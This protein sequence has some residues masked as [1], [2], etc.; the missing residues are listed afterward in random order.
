MKKTILWLLSVLAAFA[1]EVGEGKPLLV[2]AEHEVAPSQIVKVRYALSL[3]GATNA[4]PRAAL[5]SFYFSDSAGHILAP[6]GLPFSSRSGAWTYIHGQANGVS[7]EK[8]VRAPSGAVKVKVKIS[9]FA[10]GSKMRCE[11]L[12]I[13]VRDSSFLDYFRYLPIWKLCP[14][15]AVFMFFLVAALHFRFLGRNQA[16]ESVSLLRRALASLTA[17]MVAAFAFWSLGVSFAHGAKFVLD[18]SFVN[19]SLMFLFLAFL[20]IG[21]FRMLENRG[22]FLGRHPVA[23]M[24]I[25]FLCVHAMV[26]Q[27]VDGYLQMRMS[28]DFLQVQRCLQSPN[29]VVLH[30]PIFSYWCNHELLLSI[31]GKIFGPHLQVAQYLNALCCVG[32]LFPVFKLVE[33]VSGRRIATF[34]AFLVG[35]YPTNYLYST[36]LTSEYLCAFFLIWAFFFLV[37]ADQCDGDWKSSVYWLALCGANLGLAQVT[38]PFVPVF[39]ASALVMLLVLVPRIRARETCR[40]LV[41]FLILIVVFLAVSKS[42]QGLYSRIAEPQKVFAEG[43]NLKQTLVKGLDLEG[44]G[45]CSVANAKLVKSMSEKETSA[46]LAMAIKRDFKEYPVLFAEKFDRVHASEQGIMDWFSVSVKARMQVLP[47]WLKCLVGNYY[48]LFRVLFF[49]GALGFCFTALSSRTRLVPGLFSAVFVCGFAVLLMIV[50]AHG[51]YRTP[52]YPFAFVMLAYI[53]VWLTRGNPVYRRIQ[54]WLAALRGVFRRVP[55]K[56]REHESGRETGGASPAM[57]E[58]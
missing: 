5:L 28:S 42:V 26:I 52:M 29:I 2:A 8:S 31:L 10:G 56:G 44:R 9:A 22:R 45:R 53:D 55:K 35:A 58:G 46:Y 21:G 1:P 19:D 43:G 48:L 7:E 37:K 16:G 13:A 39:L 20:V 12:E 38:K 41:G 32:I 54:G 49:L 50:E 34:V 40:W 33:Q 14:W 25:F 30:P 6:D 24:S 17:G 4:V 11:C 47:Q 36:L 3:P 15:F 23:I 51:R 27:L 57:E 18:L